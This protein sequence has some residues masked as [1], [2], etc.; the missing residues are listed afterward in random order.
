ME[1]DAVPLRQREGHRTE[2]VDV[3][4]ANC[5]ISVGG[6]GGGRSGLTAKASHG[7]VENRAISIFIGRDL[8]RSNGAI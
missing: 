3:D 4:A 5:C 1:E 7:F 2:P 8:I 6:E